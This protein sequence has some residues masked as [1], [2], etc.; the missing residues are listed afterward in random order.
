[1][2]TALL[3]VYDKNGIVKFAE[4]L[5]GLGW[6]IIASG[7]TAKV[8]TEAGVSVQN[9]ADLVGGGPILGH[10]VVTLSREVHAGLLAKD[11]AEDREELERL[12][13]PW[14]DMVCVDL[15]PL[16]D[17]IAKPG[18]TRESVIEQTDIG[19][20]TMLRS[21]AK[22]RRI[23]ICDPAD[24]EKVI[25]WL[26]CGRFEEDYFI[27]N[28]VAKAE[29]TV[30]RYCL[31]SAHF[32]SNGKYE[33]VIAK[34]STACKYGENA[35]QTPAALY[36]ADSTDP[37]ALE[38][39]RL[40]AGTLPS[41]NNL[42]DLDRLLQTMTHIAAV[43][44]VNR[45]SV[46]K[47]AIGAKHGNACGA[48]IGDSAADVIQRMIEGDDVAIFGGLVMVN[49]TI[50][51]ILAEILLSW[52]MPRGERRL[53]DGI[54]APFFTEGAI[55][56]LRR[57]GDKCRFLANSVLS[58]LDASTLDTALRRRYVRGGFLS[59]PNYTFVLDLKDER[60]VKTGQL[61]TSEEN[62]LLLAWAIGSTSNS[63]TIT[64]VKDGRLIGNGV[65]QQSRVAGC[66]LAVERATEAGHY[67]VNAVAYSDS[68]FPFGDGPAVLNKA[69]IRA[70]LTSSGSVS[71]DI[72]K[73]YCAEYEMVL[74]LIPDKIGRGFFG[75]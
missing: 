33:G 28:L 22:G 14:I 11:T 36:T 71:D 5:V 48:A 56:M 2:P 7:G 73:E 72:V 18:A 25:E 49:F 39:F 38:H 29:T 44:D 55:S 42:C 50:N 66:K 63:N 13:I 51:E 58:I 32:H 30:A 68:F 41:Y 20:P 31:D 75:H 3:S 47:I 52:H 26:K 61:E 46:P 69:G 9:V 12:C 24:R 4:G 23:V 1:M 37:L 74:Y 64:L 16:Q 34:I 70:I 15:Y 45:S 62:D 8:L 53:L 19:G 65:G 67:M 40:L 6:N 17:E 21:A 60:L 35:W 57:K 27:T 10:R 54:I 59:Q 43:F